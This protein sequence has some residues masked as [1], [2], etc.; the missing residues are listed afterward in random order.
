MLD[1]NKFNNKFNNIKIGN[2]FV[3]QN[4][5]KR[6][7]EKKTENINGSILV[8]DFNLKVPKGRKLVSLLWIHLENMTLTN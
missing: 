8:K 5:P 1:T 6:I 4:L 2:V 3:K 7:H